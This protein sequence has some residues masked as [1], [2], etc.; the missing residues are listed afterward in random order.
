MKDIKG[1]ALWGGDPGVKA[2]P[3]PQSAGAGVCAF[4]NNIFEKGF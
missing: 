4:L 1:R 3:S 2:R